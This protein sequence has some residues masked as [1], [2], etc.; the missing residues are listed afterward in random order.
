MTGR[1]AQ[2]CDKGYFNP[3]NNHA[4]CKACGYALTTAGP[5]AGLTAADCITD[6]GYGMTDNK[7]GEC[8]IGAC[9]P[10]F[11]VLTTA[12]L[13][14]LTGSMVCSYQHWSGAVPEAA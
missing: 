7:M 14:S 6:K 13:A 10:D 11:V 5:G 4:A 8:P 2:K 3:G 12:V 1:G 9:M